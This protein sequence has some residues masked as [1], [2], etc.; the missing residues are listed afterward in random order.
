M[1]TLVHILTNESNDYSSN[2]FT[3]NFNLSIHAFLVYF[4]SVYSANQT[5]RGRHED[6]KARGGIFQ[7]GK[8]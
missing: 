2:F 3:A 6:L 1:T 5:I 7:N 4:T 8:K